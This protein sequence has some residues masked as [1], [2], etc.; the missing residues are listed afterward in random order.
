MIA[1]RDA[2]LT[3]ETA[4]KMETYVSPI[5]AS[6]YVGLWML[7]VIGR[8][9]ES[10]WELIGT[11]PQQLSPVTAT[12]AIEL[13]EQRYGLVPAPSATLQQRREAL[14]MK[15]TIPGAFNPHA[16]RLG[17]VNIT[18]QVPDVRENIGP[19]TFGVYLDISDG[20]TEATVRR[21]REFI[22]RRKPAHMSYEFGLSQ[23]ISANAYMAIGMHTAKIFGMRQVN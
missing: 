2:I 14:I 8:E 17:I 13:W 20:V 6:S 10:L 19:F 23:G 18:G 21:I 1:S 15:R 22:E 4:R 7:E 5:Y 12:W 11:F 16:L 3:S 9:Y